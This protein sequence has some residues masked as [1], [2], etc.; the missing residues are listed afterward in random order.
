L[1]VNSTKNT[2]R[3]KQ[4]INELSKIMSENIQLLVDRENNLSC[5]N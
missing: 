1:D 4:E 5:I 3:L 2:E